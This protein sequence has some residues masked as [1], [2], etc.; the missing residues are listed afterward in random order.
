[1]I[2]DRGRAFLIFRQNYPPPFAA[3]S[4]TAKLLFHFLASKVALALRPH[5]HFKRSGSET[6]NNIENL[7]QNFIASMS[8]L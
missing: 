4:A 1:M 3:I 2:Q 8:D 5:S 6:Q 7:N